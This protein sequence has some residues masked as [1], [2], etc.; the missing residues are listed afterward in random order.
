MPFVAM[1]GVGREMG[2]L[3]GVE[4]V[5]GE[6][7]VL[8]SKYGA[9]HCNQWDSLREGRRRGSN[10]ITLGFLVLNSY[11]H[12]GSADRDCGIL[13]A[14]HTGTASFDQPIYTL[15]FQNMSDRF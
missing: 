5:K 8:E 7:A 10:Q 1:S 3:N 13:K 14:H 11:V 2:V 12:F 4:I 15:F 9:S 6:W